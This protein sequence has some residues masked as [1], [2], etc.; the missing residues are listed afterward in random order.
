M[1]SDVSKS[2]FCVLNNPRQ[3]GYDIADNDKLLETVAFDFINTSTTRSC[4]L[5]LCLSEDG[6]EHI[7]AVFEDMT[8]FRFTALK[9]L[10]P[11]AHIEATK[12]NKKQAEDYINKVGQFSEKGEVIIA[13]FQ[14]G[15]IK[16]RQGQKFDLT[17]ADKFLSA[18]YTPREIFELDIK[19][20]RY[21]KI[22]KDAYFARLVN[23]SDLVR[24]VY[25]EW[26]FGKTGTGKSHTYVDLCEIYG[27]DD[28]YVVTDYESG[29]LDNYCGQKV[30]FLDE[31]RSQIRYSKLLSMLDSYTREFHARYSN[32][33]GLWTF[34]YIASPYAP[35]QC[36]KSLVD[37]SEDRR[38]DAVE[39]LMRR[40]D[41]IVY[42]YKD[43][44]KYKFYDFERDEYISAEAA[45]RNIR[46][47][48]DD[49]VK[50][51]D[52][53]AEQIKMMFDKE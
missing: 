26:H 36:Y 18:G 22:I 49:F 16:G 10:F 21:E 30:L 41:K 6:L 1:A 27:K 20:R 13:K 3:H 46:R 47:G 42:H 14:H 40:I 28:V 34:V 39:Q 24:N 45:A 43:C 51:P 8:A 12:G 25:V 50:L 2:W 38:I 32:I 52:P 17:E 5:T 19:Y 7:H 23:K 44:D 33:V 37:L 15:D 29:F 35:E 4:A 31:F 48:K 53:E 11:C 9:K